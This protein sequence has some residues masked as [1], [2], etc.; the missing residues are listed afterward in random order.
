ME[1][2]EL[3][4]HHQGHLLRESRVPFIFL[5][6]IL[7]GLKECTVCHSTANSIY[8]MSRTR[9]YQET[10]MPQSKCPG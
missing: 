5:E 8:M 7:F 3:V 10:S 1:L 2:Q 9:N 4:D 6:G